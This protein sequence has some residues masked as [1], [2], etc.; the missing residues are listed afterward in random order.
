M[1]YAKWKSVQSQPVVP[2]TPSQPAAHGGGT[3]VGKEKIGVIGIICCIIGFLFPIIA[4]ILWLVWRKSKPYRAQH[5]A[6]WGSIGFIV[7]IIWIQLSR[8]F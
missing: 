6:K 7:N 3:T 5:I 2:A 8:L 4:L 1:L